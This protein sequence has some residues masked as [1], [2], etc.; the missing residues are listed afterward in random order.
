MT[1]KQKKFTVRK[2]L[3][4]SSVFML[5]AGI[6]AWTYPDTALLAAALYLGVMFLI[7][8]GGYLADFYLLRSGWLLAVGLLNIIIGAVLIMNLG[9]TAASLPVLLA[10]WIL[11]LGVMQIAFGVDAR[12]A[13]E[14]AW[15]WIFLAGILG[16]LFGLMILGYPLVGVLAVSTLL[17]LYFFLY[18]CLGIAEYMEMKKIEKMEKELA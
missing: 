11:C 7:G 4:V 10:I 1:E 6:L 12:S 17:G 3:I 5:I 18:G 9:V 13:R 16:I 2:G 15:K 14:P 8:G